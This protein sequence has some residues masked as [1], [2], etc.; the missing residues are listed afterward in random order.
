MPVDKQVL[1]R[2]Q[3]L[4][5]CFR[6]KYREYT[7]D[8]LVDEC[9]EALRRADK[10]DVSKRTVQ[11]DINILEADYGI[12]LNE[13][14]R[15]GK[16]RLYRYVDTNYSIPLFRINDEERHK[17]QDAIRV[18]DHFEGEPTYD[19]ART[20]LMQIEGGLFDEDTS[21]VVTFQSNPDLK[22]ISYFSDL[23]QAILTKR[24][25]KLKYTPY[26]KETQIVNIYPYHL[27]QFNDRWYLIAQAIGYQSYAHY[28]LDRIEGFEEIALPY[29]ES[30]VDFS[31]YFDDVIGVTVPDVD[32]EDI[33][34]KVTGKRFNYIRTKPLHLSQRVIE[35]TEGYAI[36]SINVKVNKELESLIL[37]FGD[38]MEVIAPASF[39]DRIAEKIKVMNQL[40]SKDKDE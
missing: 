31:E 2:Y 30:D 20:L 25:L 36:I 29:K 26:G 15:L 17:L 16:K 6:N 23:L 1:L 8:D 7:I 14:L 13:K 35:E 34:I 24:V 18:L 38:D 28:A 33:V 22:G 9:N 5:K 19:W 10:P 11:N 21:P 39:R 4:N 32:A 12:I 40:Y 37:S 3:V 27:K